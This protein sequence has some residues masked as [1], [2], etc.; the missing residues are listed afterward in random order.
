M[1]TV[2]I[3]VLESTLTELQTVLTGFHRA[4]HK[5]LTSTHCDCMTRMTSGKCNCWGTFQLSVVVNAHSPPTSSSVCLTRSSHY[6]ADI[7]WLTTKTASILHRSTFN[8]ISRFEACGWCFCVFIGCREKDFLELSSTP[9]C[10]SKYGP[11]T[12]NWHD[13]MG[14]DDARKKTIISVH[15]STQ[16]RDKDKQNT[17]CCVHF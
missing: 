10:R 3:V 4:Q 8:D 11:G 5:F 17:Q 14:V 2:N 1:S 7:T 15:G 16:G 9:V 12:M 6:L 13:A